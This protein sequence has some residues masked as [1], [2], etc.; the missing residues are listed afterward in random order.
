MKM[1]LRQIGSRFFRSEHLPTTTSTWVAAER[2]HVLPPTPHAQTPCHEPILSPDL[3]KHLVPLVADLEHS[4]FL[5]KSHQ[6]QTACPA[7]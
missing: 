6:W 1:M 4:R 5:P 3:F 7:Q 2:S